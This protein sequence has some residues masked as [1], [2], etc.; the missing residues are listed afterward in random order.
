MTSP[1]WPFQTSAHDIE[2]TGAE[3]AWL[4][5]KS[6][7][8]VLD[9]CGGAIVTNIG[10]G[11]AEVGAAAARAMTRASYVLPPFITEERTALVEMLRRDWLPAH[12]PRAF[13]AAGGSE[14]NDA[15]IRMA[16]YYQIARGQP[17]RTKILSRTISY[18]GTTMATLAL[19]GHPARRRGME[20]YL[21]EVPK[22]PTPYPLRFRPGPD[23][24]GCGEAAAR[25]LEELILAEGPETI[26]A[27]IGEPVIGASGGAIV[28]PDD[29]WPA[30]ARIL[31]RHDILFIAD[32]VMTGFGRTGKRFA[33]EHWGVEPDILVS[34]KGLTG[35]YAPLCGVFTREEIAAALERSGQ[36]MMYYTYGAASGA[37][38]AALAVLDILHKEDLV[39]RSAEMGAS[40]M[41]SLSRRLGQHPHVAEIRGKGLLIGLEIVA[42]RTSL[43]PFPA[44]AGVQARILRN[45]FR[46]G[47]MVYAAGNG[48]VRDCL[49]LGPPFILTSSE[50]D[51]LVEAIATGIDK[52]IGEIAR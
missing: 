15:A 50:A 11:R 5:L 30:V 45:I 37:C 16:R 33:V 44:E 42:D 49:L 36:A 47:A 25:A 13:F 7:Q 22:A 31:K 51:G 40:L 8:R 39:A 38:G 2:L 19:S 27:F 26:S 6:G 3:G 41:T 1:L 32:E 12:L 28:P 18:H 9:A 17:R 34:G 35:G 20:P 46:S 4:H 48:D 52:G 29:Y 10:H 24:A 14:A 21:M 43:A 23:G